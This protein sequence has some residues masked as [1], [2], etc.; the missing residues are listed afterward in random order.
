MKTLTLA[1]FAVVSSAALAA[2]PKT[3]PAAPAASAFV[4]GGDPKKGE[5]TFKTMCASCHGDSGKGDGAAAAALNPK[6]AD[7]TD[8]ARAAAATD[9][10]IYKMVK[11][12]GAANGKS[13]LMVA[14]GP[15]LGDDAKV[16]DVAAYVRTLSKGKAAAP[17]AAAPAAKKAG[18]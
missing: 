11:D 6:P 10:Y 4:L 3:A 7:F 14:W 17:A 13:P 2:T 12:G 8:P 16:R 18:K 9:E 15:A 5:A 1:L